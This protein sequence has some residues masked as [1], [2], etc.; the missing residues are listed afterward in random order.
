MLGRGVT[1][2]EDGGVAV[3]TGD[4]RGVVAADDAL[5]GERIGDAS[6][7]SRRGEIAGDDQPLASSSHPSSR[8]PDLR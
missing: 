2:R 4:P 3:I 1:G 6:G 7:P 8:S 5:R